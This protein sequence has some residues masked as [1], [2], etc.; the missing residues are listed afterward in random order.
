[1]DFSSIFRT[2]N[3]LFLYLYVTI[4]SECWCNKLLKCI[5]FTYQK[6]FFG[7]RYTLTSDKMTHRAFKT[8]ATLYTRPI[9]EIF[10]C[11]YLPKLYQNFNLMK[12]YY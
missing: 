6:I 12:M 9:R 10:D 8:H 5:S 2:L 11:Y 1:M 4:F 3:V 7:Q